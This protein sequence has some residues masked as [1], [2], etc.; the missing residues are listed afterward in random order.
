MH[1]RGP[2]RQRLGRPGVRAQESDFSELDRSA[3]RWKDHT[4][5]WQTLL[6]AGCPQWEPLL[7]STR[8][9]SNFKGDGAFKRVRIKPSS[10]ERDR[11]RGEARARD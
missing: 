11:K 1:T 5:K 3:L 10:S 7:R 4:G 2:Q 6:D 9:F 8:R